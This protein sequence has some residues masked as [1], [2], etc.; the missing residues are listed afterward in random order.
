MEGKFTITSFA[1]K[2]KTGEKISVLTA[3]DYP[4]AKLLDGEV[5]VLL[6]GDSLGMVKLGYEDT[7]EVT[8]DDMVYHTRSVKRGASR[9]FIVTDMPYLSYHI[10]LE[11]SVRNAGRI[12]IEGKANAVKLEGGRERVEVVRKLVDS[13][14][15]VMGHLGLTPQSVN[16][17]GG[18]KVQARSA[19]AGEKLLQDALSLQDAGVFAIVLECIPEEIAKYVTDSV[20]VPTIGIGAGRHCDGQVLVVDDMLGI[21]EDIHPK[22]VKRYGKLGEE[23]RAMARE[24]NNEVKSGA[25]P[26]EVHIFKLE[27]SE[28]EKIERIY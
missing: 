5:D 3:Y 10:S 12:M 20:S 21:T 17:T 7:L 14:I 25:F 4:T 8:V 19:D 18:F 22:F 23:I 13:E 9:S 27:K 16:A 28:L 24:Y 15:P 1:E 2:K 26:E 11:E 6:V